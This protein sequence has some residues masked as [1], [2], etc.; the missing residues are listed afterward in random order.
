MNTI[1]ALWEFLKGKKTYLLAA[2]GA[3]VAVLAWSGVIDFE[4]ANK[5]LAI[6]GF[7]GL[8]ALRASK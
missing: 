5:I 2:A 4:T 8:A 7:G 6:L 1:K 3:V